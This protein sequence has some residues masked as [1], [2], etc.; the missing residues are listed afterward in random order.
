ML[1]K[2]AKMIN[3]LL[4]QNK[5]LTLCRKTNSIFFSNEKRCICLLPVAIR[6]P[7]L[8]S[9]GLATG[10]CPEPVCDLRQLPRSLPYTGH[11]HDK[12]GESCGCCRPTLL[13]S[14]YRLWQD[15]PRGTHEQ[16][17][18]PHVVEGH[19]HSTRIGH[20]RK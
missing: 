6:C 20:R 13:P 3:L 7:T 8:C 14:G 18:W 10:S 4:F 2:N 12:Q 5:S 15:R 19:R 11:R 9:T 16:G 1:F 17:Q